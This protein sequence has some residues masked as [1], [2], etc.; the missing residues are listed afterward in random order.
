MSTLAPRA[1]NAFLKEK[2]GSLFFLSNVLLPNGSAGAARFR[3]ITR[4][5]CTRKGRAEEEGKKPLAY[6]T[7]AAFISYRRIQPADGLPAIHR[8]I[9]KETDR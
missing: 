6:R 3:L 5:H 7:G 4:R 9:K 2:E 8:M 1:H